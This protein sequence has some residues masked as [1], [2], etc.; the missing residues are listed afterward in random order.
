MT[1]SLSGERSVAVAHSSGFAASVRRHFA[2]IRADKARMKALKTLLEY[3]E[4]RLDDLGICRQDVLDALAH[5]A[6][7]GQF[8]AFRRSARAAR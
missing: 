7:A 4:F 5:R 3:D 6:P 1:I 8:L 2:Q